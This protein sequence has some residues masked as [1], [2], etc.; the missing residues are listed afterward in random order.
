MLL[1]SLHNKHSLDLQARPNSHTYVDPPAMAQEV[2]GPRGGAVPLSGAKH[3]VHCDKWSPGMRCLRFPNA[4][5]RALSALLKGHGRHV[6]TAADECRLCRRS[7]DRLFLLSNCSSHQVTPRTACICLPYVSIASI[8]DRLPSSDCWLLT[9]VPMCRS[10]G[11][12]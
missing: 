11:C 1:S 7:R 12:T 4:L 6:G 9:P 2:Q 3:Q 5:C 8:W 10:G